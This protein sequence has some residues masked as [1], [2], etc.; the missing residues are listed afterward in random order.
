MLQMTNDPSH[1]VASIIA[2]K[3]N[4]ADIEPGKKQKTTQRSRVSELK[5]H[6]RDWISFHT[7]GPEARVSG[8]GIQEF[9]GAQVLR[10]IITVGT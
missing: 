3:H 7:A 5:G 1:H 4:T 2:D 10:S 9:L 6:L 8:E